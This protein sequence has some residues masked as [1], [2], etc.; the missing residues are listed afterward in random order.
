LALT[1][2]VC[3]LEESLLAKQFGGGLS[4]QWGWS[5]NRYIVIYNG[6][7]LFQIFGRLI[8][9]SLQFVGLWCGH[10]L[11][12]LLPV[13]QNVVGQLSRRRR[14]D[15]GGDIAGKVLSFLLGVNFFGK[16][17]LGAKS[18]CWV[19]LER[20]PHPDPPRKVPPALWF[21]LVNVGGQPA[22]KLAFACWGFQQQSLKAQ[23]SW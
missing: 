12:L 3:V 13:I 17:R 16:R 15:H 5:V 19:S 21:P 20:C 2:T 7:F 4:C 23:K 6:V 1:T 18:L 22:W 11:I 14:S 8:G 9:K 10:H